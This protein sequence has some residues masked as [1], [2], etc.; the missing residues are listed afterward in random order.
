MVT[1]TQE[2]S[3]TLQTP[4]YLLS[5]L[6]QR[7]LL[8]TPD[9]ASPLVTKFTR[10]DANVPSTSRMK[11]IMF[12]NTDDFQPITQ[13]IGTDHSTP[14][15]SDLHLENATV[16]QD[17]NCSP[18]QVWSGQICLGTCQDPK[19][20]DFFMSEYDFCICPDPFLTNG[21]DCVPP[22][23]CGCFATEMGIVIRVSNTMYIYSLQIK[24][25][26]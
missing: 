6:S 8:F 14:F 19:P 22:K 4:M 11:S 9:E 5:Y 10:E 15:T 16:T 26:V 20:C 21:D 7:I 2:E 3:C 25:V 17:D 12:E 13:H 23:D 18:N 24:F 1:P